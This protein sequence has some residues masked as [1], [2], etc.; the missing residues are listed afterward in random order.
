MGAVNT[1]S[2][3]LY[4]LPTFV[5]TL[6]NTKVP[7]L[8]VLLADVTP[9]VNPILV[10]LTSKTNAIK[11]YLFVQIKKQMKSC[12]KM[13]LNTKTQN[14]V[15]AYRSIENKHVFCSDVYTYLSADSNLLTHHFL[16]H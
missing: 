8:Q 10:E 15:A 13:I 14:T 11:K 5:M 3:R 2:L 9:A 12:L 4:L 16:V 1:P 6:R 7:L